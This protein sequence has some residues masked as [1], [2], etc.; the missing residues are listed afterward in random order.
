MALHISIQIFRQEDLPIAVPAGGYDASV[1]QLAERSGVNSQV[2]GSGF[3]REEPPVGH[4]DE[5]DSLSIEAGPLRMRPAPASVGRPVEELGLQLP[6][7]VARMR[8]QSNPVASARQM[9]SERVLRDTELLEATYRRVRPAAQCS[10]RISW[11]LRMG[12]LRLATASP[13]RLRRMGRLAGLLRPAPLIRSKDGVWT[14][15]EANRPPFL[16]IPSES[17]AF[18]RN[19]WPTRLGIS[20]IRYFLDICLHAH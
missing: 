3:Q 6:G 9:Y 13:F 5:G 4:S 16:E 19:Q 7:L 10:L 15:S 17:A 11:V 18:H 20:T 8:S 2:A 1:G 14:D 12:N